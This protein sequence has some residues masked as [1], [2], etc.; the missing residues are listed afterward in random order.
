MIGRV[1]TYEIAL[2]L[3]IAGAVLYFG[4]ILLAGVAFFSARG[5]DRPGEIA[6]VLGLAR[7]GV[8]IALPGAALLLGCGFW[9]IDLSG[10]IDVGDG[11]ISAALALLVGSVVIG[12]VA[13]QGPKRARKLAARLAADG[14]RRTPELERL[15][16]D[17]PSLVLN[18]VAG[19]ASVAVLVLM[20]W[21]PGA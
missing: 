16:A 13:G 11:W 19:L 6:A 20:V 14:D 17:R 8:L 18:L 3:H 12:G 9:L 4:G 21:K 5:R 7:T 15:L 10:S 2:L 1:S